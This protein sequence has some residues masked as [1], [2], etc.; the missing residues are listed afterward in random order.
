MTATGTC[1]RCGTPLYRETSAGLCPR[2]LGAFGFGRASPAADAVPVRDNPP[3]L[4]DYELLEEIA[5]GG[6]GVVYRARQISLDRTVALKVVLHGS[7]SSPESVRRFCTEAAV[8][9]G[10]RHPNIVAIHEVGQ[11]ETEH[12]FS[13][14]YIEGNNLGEVA[15]EQPWAARRAAQCL[16]TIAEAVH[17]AHQRGVLHRDLKPSNVLLDAFGEPHITDFGLAKVLGTDTELTLTGQVLGSPSYIAP[18]Q[19]AGKLDEVG[20]GSDIYSLGAVLYQLLTGRPPFQGETLPE[21]L[22]QVRDEEP[23]LPRRLNPS[24][25]ADLQTI[26]LKC[27]QKEPA[28]RYPTAQELAED[29]ARFLAQEPIRARPVFPL[30]KLFLWGKRRPAL[31]ALILALHFV[32]LGG[33]IGVLW[34]WRRAEESVRGEREQRRVAE[35]FASRVQLNLYAGD[36]SFAAQ[37]LQ[38]SDLGL[39]RRTLAGLKPEPGEKDLRGFEWYYLWRQCHGDQLATL[40]SHDWIVTC[41]AFSPDGKLLATG[42]EDA[43]V[44]IWEVARRVLV[45]TLSALT[46][47]VLSVEF[48]PDNRQLVTAGQGGTYVWD[49]AVWQITNVFEGQFASLARASPLL[50]TAETSYFQWWQPP[51]AVRIW[52]YRTGEQIFELPILRR[53]IALAPDGKTL[54][55]AGLERGVDLWDVAAGKVRQTL[56]TSNAVRSLVFSRDGERLIAVVRGHSPLLFELNASVPPRKLRGH[57]ME[58]WGASFSPDGRQIATTS[59]DQTLRLWNATSLEPQQILRGH[60]HEVWCVAFSPDGKTL[61]SGSKDCQ[62]MLWSAE[63]RE[64]EPSLPHQTVVRPFFS[65]AGDKIVTFGSPEAGTSSTL[66]DLA[67]AP[68]PQTVPGKRVLGFSPDGKQLIRWGRYIHSLEY[69]SLDAT[70]AAEVAL[71]GSDETSKNLQHLGFT[72]DWRQFFTIDESG[73]ARVWEAA[74]GKLLHVL[75]G[76]LKVSAVALS[77]EGTYLALAER[78][79]GAVWLFDCVTGR[80]RRLVGHK[81]SILCLAFSGDNQLLASGSL[82]GK[83]RLWN[84]A[85]G[86]QV[87]ELPGHMEETSGLA[88]SP[89]GRTLASVDEKVSV[90]LWHI[91]TRRELISWDFPPAGDWIGFSPEGR[92]LAVTTQTNS[93]HLFAAPAESR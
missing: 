14:D 62:V 52:N 69:L 41:A 84:P 33:I 30:E 50:A 19:A 61:A 66:W 71:V 34:Q 70:N 28:R 31:A 36:V 7:F 54:A 89:D 87:A 91:A 72:P 55:C 60:E 25:P 93:I 48:T 57:P 4:G 18:E 2:C 20:P 12:F 32:L 37:A 27:L 83:I 10:L 40:G 79:N 59:S 42:S 22:L 1:P 46:G 90:K 76:P 6:M 5:R 80:E 85:T 8:V 51:G 13:M 74:T 29:L 86:E 81:D 39:A 3:R 65:P 49:C 68:M 43:T 77:P 73:R 92:F 11:T 88:F 45:T 26:C 75:S 17:Y 15:R 67:D 35:E 82:D 16:K 38:R 64:T 24:V 56:A 44:K 53:V 21:I 58:V 78:Q 23:V 63:S 9:A 47:A